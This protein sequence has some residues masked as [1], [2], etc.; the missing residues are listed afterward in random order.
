MA[1]YPTL[2]CYPGSVKTPSQNADAF[3]DGA[4][5]HHVYLR[6][7]KARFTLKHVVTVAQRDALDAFY[8]ANRLLSN[9]SF[10]WYEDNLVYTVT[11]LERPKYEAVGSSSAAIPEF[12]NCSVELGEA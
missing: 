10:T 3:V 11:F 12:R 2:V 9:I 7:Q 6:P 5:G 8:A 1:A 4:G